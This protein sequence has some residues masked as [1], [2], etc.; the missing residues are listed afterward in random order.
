MYND[1][2]QVSRLLEFWLYVD[3]RTMTDWKTHRLMTRNRS[4]KPDGS[5]T[6]SPSYGT[7]NHEADVVCLFLD[8]V[9][10]DMHVSTLWNGNRKTIKSAKS[11]QQQWLAGI[12]SP[13]T[14]EVVDVNTNFFFGAYDVN[15]DPLPVAA[16]AKHSQR[17]TY[18]Y[19]YDDQM[20]QLVAAF[21]DPVYA[22]IAL[23]GY[24]TGVR[25]HEA[26]AIPWYAIDEKTCTVFSGDPGYLED[27]IRQCPPDK[28]DSLQ[29]SLKVL[30]KGKK[31]RTVKFPARGWL[32]LMK[33]WEPLRQ[34]RKKLYKEREGKECPDWILWLDKKGEPLY[35]PPGNDVV[36]LKPLSKLREAFYHISTRKKTPLK[37]IFNQAVS[38]YT[39]R[40]TFATNFMIKTMIDRNNYNEGD[41]LN[42]LRL[43]QE[44]ADQ[45]GHEAFDT[46]F[47]YYIIHSIAITQGSIKGERPREAFTVENLFKYLG[48]R[49]SLRK[50][51]LDEKMHDGELTDPA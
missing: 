38:Y 20:A 40:H 23:T 50:R 12:V 44:L 39:M 45:L 37:K 27:C 3:S 43:Q 31:I 48:K 9:K 36:H 10:H 46:T 1:E 15:A 51:H 41:Y 33:K 6:S 35:C 18:Q 26:L 29:I 14:K 7:V 28:R 42:D 13:G 34:V 22:H 30:G 11:I 25:P 21:P 24:L 4:H 8:W 49:I 2:D 19:L 32:A 47:K 17:D 16:H 5:R